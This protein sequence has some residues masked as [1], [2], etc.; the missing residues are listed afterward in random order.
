MR[1]RRA[2]RALLS[3]GCFV[4][5]IAASADGSAQT[6]A[7]KA[8]SHAKSEATHA[9]TAQSKNK[10]QSKG[11]P[12]APKH[13]TKKPRK[14][15]EPGEADE[16]TRK[17][18]AGT[19]GAA[20][21]GERT[22]SPELRAMRELD[23]AL[24]P[25]AKP[26]IGSIWPSD[27]IAIERDRPTVVANGVPPASELLPAPSAEPARDLTWL[28][29]LDMPDIP[30]RWDARVVRYL[31]FY[32]DNPRGRSMV[33]GWI[34]KS[35]R[36]GGAIRRVLREQGLPEDVLWLSLVESG[37]DPTI[38]SAAGAAGLWQ[39]MPDGARIYGLTVD[40][41]V[42]ERLDPE[43]S[44]VAAAK[45]LSDLRKRFGA[46]EL[47]FAAYNMGYGGLLASIRKYNTNDYW[48]LSRFEAGIPYETALY[49]PKIVAMAIVARNKK[50]F[51][52]DDVELDPAV[53]FDRVS[54]GSG[55]SI[56]AIASA[57]GA[58]ERDVQTLNPQLLAGRTP[59]IVPGMKEDTAWVVRV[60]PG[61]ASKTANNVAKLAEQEGKLERYLVRW[62]ESIEDIA[63]SRGVAKTTL[64]NLNGLRREEVVRPGTVLFVPAAPGTG[65]AAAAK[66]VATGPDT[67]PLVIVPSEKWTYPDRRRVFYR[68][69]PGDTLRDVSDVFSV[70]PDEITRWNGLDPSAS[71][72]DGMTLQVF[73][74]K[75]ARL[76]DVAVLEEKDARL[77]TV[78][79]DA[80]FAHFEGLK[81]R[82]RMEV[83]VREGE[84]FKSI[85]AH[86]GL[87]IGLLER[88]N[89]RARSSPLQP[90]DKLVVYV[91]GKS[92][93]PASVDTAED[94]SDVARASATPQDDE[95]YAAADREM[96]PAALKTTPKPDEEFASI[97]KAEKSEGKPSEK[98]KDSGKPGEPAKNSNEP[99]KSPVKAVDT[100]KQAEAPKQPAKAAETAKPSESAKPSETAKPS[101]PAKP[102]A[103]SEPKSAKGAAKPAE[104]ARAG[105]P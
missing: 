51:G 47:A 50:V 78:G 74:S 75:D 89:Q 43:R 68:P 29:Q 39:F 46:W 33:A 17:I 56:H 30:V 70:T 26:G 85:A 13:V 65:T 16:A 82:K 76:D 38:G 21:P 81:G 58:S 22:E 105:A 27:T 63:T 87:S 34:K 35:G 37:F 77:M 42:D 101:E 103:S 102:P 24:F 31:E 10:G 18:I 40:R 95:M 72:H 2:A 1:I 62:G 64:A 32:K 90:G 20:R 53:T 4:S 12:K 88:I 14:A 28:K 5:L 79:S 84:S 61:A 67:K 86:H 48:E 9:P 45:Y 100:A 54:V 3:L 98:A 96:M 57:A 91:P 97:A 7:P 80:F 60:P 93:P 52:C 71:L 15:G 44:T 66:A 25:E 59:P 55:I 94:A 23:L 41:W 19:S 99:S 49:V 69:V 8:A 104:S 73:V 11:S 83:V 92:T 36:Y 6:S